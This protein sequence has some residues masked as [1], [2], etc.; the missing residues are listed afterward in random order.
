MSIKITYKKGINEKK[1]KNFVLFSDQ[2]FKING[3]RN[4]SL[5]KNSNQIIKTINSNK[6]KD[7]DFVSFNI[8][9]DQKIIL[10][11]IKDSKS[12][13]ENEKKVLF[14]IIFQNRIH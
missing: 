8:N 4:L 5:A 3:L 12:S 1:I 9:P 6:S 10:I 7:K 11:K 14:F 13:T 2:E